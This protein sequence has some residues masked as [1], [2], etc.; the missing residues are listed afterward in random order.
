MGWKTL[1]R[2]YGEKIL[3]HEPGEPGTVQTDDIEKHFNVICLNMFVL[4]IEMGEVDALAYLSSP[5]T[6]TENPYEE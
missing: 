4:N 6:V 5:V 2:K 1:T 3:G